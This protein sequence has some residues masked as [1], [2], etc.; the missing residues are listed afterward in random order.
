MHLKMVKIGF[1]RREGCW[2]GPTVH[3]FSAGL[4]RSH[5]ACCFSAHLS[6]SRPDTMHQQVALHR[7]LSALCRCSGQLHP[8][9]QKADRHYGKTKQNKKKVEEVLEEEEEEYAVGHS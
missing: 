8:L 6:S 5:L 4:D 3:R 1:S 7:S 9:Y 2:L